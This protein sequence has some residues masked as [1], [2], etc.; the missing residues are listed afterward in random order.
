MV[1]VIDNILLKGKTVADSNHSWHHEAIARASSITWRFNFQLLLGPGLNLKTTWGSKSSVSRILSALMSLWI[2]R[3]K[4]LSWRYRRPSA[5]PKAIL[6]LSFQPSTL[7][8]ESG[9]TFQIYLMNRSSKRPSKIKNRILMNKPWRKDPKLPS[10]DNW[11][12]RCIPSSTQLPINLAVLGWFTWA[13]MPSS[14]RNPHVFSSV[15]PLV[16]RFTAIR[17][18]SFRQ[19]L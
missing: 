5:V 13:M 19:P 16:I 4:H 11:K 8:F 9:K 15:V 14:D 2:I 18:P 1:I 6:Y 12:T 7:S 10:W 17:C 3:F